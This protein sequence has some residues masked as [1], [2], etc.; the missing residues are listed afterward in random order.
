[1]LASKSWKIA[2]LNAHTSPRRGSIDQITHVFQICHLEDGAYFGELAL[3][4]EDERWI[5]SVIAAENSEVFVLSRVDF[6]YI[7]TP[8]PDL[9]THLQNIV[10]ARPEQTSLFEKA[11]ELNSPTTVSGNVNISSIKV[12]RRD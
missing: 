1:M 10:L 9:L 4:M 6:Q 7:L 12:K 3:L 5:A 8:Y 11:R 2:N